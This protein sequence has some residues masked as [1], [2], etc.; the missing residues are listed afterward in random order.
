MLL[1]TTLATIQYE[2]IAGIFDV[3]LYD[4]E[5]FTDSLKRISKN[6]ATPET[7]RQ[8]ENIERTELLSAGM[9]L[10]PQTRKRSL[11][12]SDKNRAGQMPKLMQKLLSR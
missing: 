4:Y 5:Q 8:I 6:N 3:D 7:S 1:I 10:L 9:Q 12:E 2:T 11:S